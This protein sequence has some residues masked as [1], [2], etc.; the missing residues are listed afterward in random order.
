MLLI[1]RQVST[2]FGGRVDLLGIDREGDLVILEL[3]RDRTP[4]EVIAQVL[5]YASWVRQLTYPEIDAIALDYLDE[6]L[7]I[8]FSEFFGE[9]IPENINTNHKMLV[10]ASELDD[11]SERIVDYLAEEYKVNINVIFFSFFKYADQEL[12]GRAWLMDPEKVQERAETRKQAP[13]LGYWFVNVGEGEH[14]N[15]EDNVAYGYVGAGQGEKYS[16]ALKTLKAGD[17]VFAYVK[18][19]GYTGY[20]EVIKEA[21]MVKDFFVE[22]EGKH[23]LDP[24][25]KAPHASENSED[26]EFSDW[27][28]GVDWIKT[29]PREEA[30]TFKGVF[31]NQ[32]VVCKLRHEATVDFLETNFIA[33]N[34]E[35]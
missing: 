34:S 35:T 8:T 16:K 33:N 26:S 14:R 24:P 11:S 27:A 10:V 12:L 22:S 21:T 6:S 29:V 18:G 23:L 9:A 4:R 19:R 31:A 30:R 7:S 1:G 28:V 3:K 13:W 32:N 5:D 2:E 20:G 15:W 25:L 17:N